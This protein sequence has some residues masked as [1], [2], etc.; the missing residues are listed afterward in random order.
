MPT[1]DLPVNNLFACV[2]PLAPCQWHKHDSHL[3]LKRL[4]YSF[5]LL[6]LALTILQRN[7]SSQT[8]LQSL[9][10]GWRFRAVSAPEHKDAEQWTPAT[11]P[12]V[13]QTDLRRAG[14]IP[15]PFFG[16]NEQALQ[17]IGTTDWEYTDEFDADPATLHRR[18]AELIFEGLDT[19]ADVSVNGQPLLHA[20]NMFR[21]WHVDVTGRLRPHNTLRIIFHSPVNTMA[22][23][24]AKLP[25]IIPGTGYEPLEP[26]KGIYP[27]S[28][29]V[30]KA[31]YSFGWDW[32]PRLITSGVWRPVHLESWNNAR[33]TAF[34]LHQSSV[35]AER[36]VAQAELDLD[37]D[38]ASPHAL[39]LITS[40]APSGAAL[41][42][43]RIPI[44]LDAGANH[45]IV[46][47][48]IERPQRWYPNGYGP[49]ALYSFKATLIDGARLLDSR[50]LRTGLRSL[51][52]RRE[53]DAWGKS[54]TFVVNGI[55]IFA[56]GAN[57]V[58]PDSFPPDV[59][60]ERRLKILTAAHDAHMNM[61][62]VWGGGYYLPDDFYEDADR[63]GLLIWHDFMFGGSMIPHDP[64]YL[65]NVRAEAREQV[66]RL[67][68]HPSI[69][70]W[71]G[72][73]EV[74]TAWHS[75]DDRQRFKAALTPDQREQVWQDYLLVFHDML[76]SAVA[77]FGNNVPYW[78]S[79]PSADF[80]DTAGST[81]DGDVHSWTVWS[82]GAPITE[83]ASTTPRFL[84]EFGFQ[85][86]PDLA[87]VR[88]FVG[89][90]QDLTSPALLDHERF[91][92]GFTRMQQYLG[93]Q[94]RQ[95]R[96][97]AAMVYLSQ[98]MQAE[99][100]KFAVE[101]MRS[102]R[103][104]NMG[105][106]FWQLDDCWP[107]VS[108]SSIDYF[109]R[110]K[111]LEFYAR[112]FYAPLLV[113]AAIENHTVHV[114]VVS[115]ETTPRDARLHWR[116]LTFDGHTVEEKQSPASVPALA[117]TAAATI[118]LDSVAG[119][120][121]THD[122]LA[123]SLEDATGKQLASQNVYFDPPKELALPNQ[124]ITAT[125]EDDVSGPDRFLVI[126]HATTLARAVEISFGS[127]DA[128]PGDNFFDLL[129]GQ[130]QRV[131]IRS[132]AP[133]EQLRAAVRLTS[134]V[135]ATQ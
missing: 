9:A 64:A 60:P 45:F 1:K 89:S 17:W 114:M 81:R 88:A 39:L 125:V 21:S 14:V 108:W 76:K 127:L 134:V 126:L 54:F 90:D 116:L 51:E 48:R 53:P 118:D 73:N 18:H 22:A 85:A 74:E 92:H 95:P 26:S 35:T 110:P 87:T 123:L 113:T 58:P 83:Y 77:E 56:K 41:P 23:T 86:M 27:T 107:A 69:A 70:L 65:D 36:A 96:D 101:S 63:L 66:Q 129:P 79:S 43:L 93:K 109:L 130:T 105:T 102:R 97:F 40:T 15:D 20:D 115:D 6:A 111:A 31:A 24:A 68:D 135:S 55:P 106:L 91:V 124:Q 34:H 104:Q 78:P 131:R 128:Q 121:P 61:L 28:Q 94:F 120:D 11:V 19:F 32:A 52:L 10:N 47:M 112:R 4:G 3:C 5:V 30:R 99:A 62:R 7:A 33:I 119:F 8:Y 67:S 38:H 42:S 57:F 75:W 16:D 100:I 80:E 37:T 29:Y 2:E 12:G 59:T 44:V 71:C 117:S 84:S 133:L 103:P 132:T 72:N 49:Q 25:Y 98:V 82:A 122:V 50:I 46:P 13:V